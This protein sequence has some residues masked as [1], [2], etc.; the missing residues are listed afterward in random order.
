VKAEHEYEW[1]GG[2]GQKVER[3][4]DSRLSEEKK[5]GQD[6]ERGAVD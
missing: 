6:R 5:E 4:R 2:C 3:C 1:W